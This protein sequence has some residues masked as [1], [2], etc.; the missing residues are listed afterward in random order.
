MLIVI[1]PA[2]SLDFETPPITNH[3][4]QPRFLD[5]SM[6]LIQEA[7][8]LEPQQIASLMKISDKLATLNYQ[9]YAD[10]ALPFTPENAKQAV[11]AFTG[12]V[13][14][15]LD[16]NSFLPEDFDRAQRDL[17]ILSGLYGLLRPLDLIQPYRL[18][19]GIAF[20]N[21]RGKNLYSFWGEKLTT[22]LNDDMAEQ[23]T[24]T[25]INLAS[26]EYFKAVL[27]K[28]LKGQVITP[29]FKDERNG[30]YKIIS[31]FAKKARG[32]M[33]RY[34]IQKKIDSPEALKDFDAAGYRYNDALSTPTEWA[35]TRQQ[36]Q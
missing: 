10:W 21:E 14:H 22:C 23:G 25:L 3:Y 1:S 34:I 29:I 4:T 32:I 8:E 35:F 31:F 7:R 27:T 18:E 5:D 12:D 33:S 16:A 19:M 36:T 26:N 11:L 24:D 28:S 17:R 13:Y 30:Q 15:G 6:A 9:R 20:E 2:K